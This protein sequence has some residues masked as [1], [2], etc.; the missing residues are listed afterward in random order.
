M[1]HYNNLAEL[2]A[3][4]KYLTALLRAVL[5]QTKLPPLPASTSWESVFRLAKMHSVETMAF[6]GAEKMISEHGELFMQWKNK[7]DQNLVQSM[8]QLEE[9]S[10]LYETFSNAGIRFVPL[11]GCV[12]KDL[13]PQI[14]FRQMADLDI[15]IEAE[16][17]ETVRLLMENAGYETRGFGEK[18][19]DEYFMYPY[20]NVEI[21]KQMLPDNVSIYRYYDDIWNR[22]TP[23]PA[24]PG[25]WRMTHEDF[26]IYQLAHFAKHFY[27]MGSGIR[28]VMDIYVYLNAFSD[29]IDFNYIEKELSALDLYQF[30]KQMKQLSLSWFSPA[31]KEKSFSPERSLKEIQKS[32]FLAGVYGS[33]E[34]VKSRTMDSADVKSGILNTAGYL[35]NRIF[36]SR[37]EFGYAYPIT[38]KYPAL[39]LIFWFYRII[40][41]LL[42]KR[43]SVKREIELFHSKRK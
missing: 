7:R 17:A 24:I 11:K 26:Y 16:H 14:D 41:I 22:V 2:E 40:D 27:E 1:A 8:I 37:E 28:S 3:T 20:M 38:R 33:R 32:I 43:D 21:H 19:A 31:P 29:Q 25:A 35:W 9:K 5:N 23:D 30:G 13:Y 6:Y 34:F 15:L 10:K 36:M 4:G 39:I 18:H 42:H 12:L